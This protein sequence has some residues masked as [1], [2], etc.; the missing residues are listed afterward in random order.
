M[1]TRAPC[2]HWFAGLG[3]HIIFE[4][5]DYRYGARS[6]LPRISVTSSPLEKNIPTGSFPFKHFK[7][8]ISETKVAEQNKGIPCS[9]YTLISSLYP[10]LSLWYATPSLV[11]EGELKTRMK[12]PSLYLFSNGFFRYDVIDKPFLMVASA[13]A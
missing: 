3:I 10:A 6:S 8:D 5:P 11:S 9:R 2:N 1:N 4:S 7:T 13:H 12:L